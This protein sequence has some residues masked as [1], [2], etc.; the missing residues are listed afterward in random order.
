MGSIIVSM[1]R[2]SALG[3]SLLLIMQGCLTVKSSS[4]FT[5]VSPKVAPL[6]LSARELTQNRDL[7]ITLEKTDQFNTNLIVDAGT[8]ISDRRYQIEVKFPH[9]L[10]PKVANAVSRE[11]CTPG[12]LSGSLIETAEVGGVAKTAIIGKKPGK[13]LNE[14]RSMWCEGGR[15]RLNILFR[16][17]LITD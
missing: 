3:L 1:V 12:C 4:T 7:S 14:K 10:V 16:A 6:V 5:R 8:L 11:S 15:E 9:G 13:T 2:I 17:K